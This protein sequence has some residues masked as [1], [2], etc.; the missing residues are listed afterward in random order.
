ML[1]GGRTRGIRLQLLIDTDLLEKKIYTDLMKTAED[2]SRS[3]WRDCH[4]PVS[5]FTACSKDSIKCTLHCR[6]ST[7]TNG[8]EACRKEL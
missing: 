1:G 6:K 7:I 5:G 2:T 4:K 8:T 3:V